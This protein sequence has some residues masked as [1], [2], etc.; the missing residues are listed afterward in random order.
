M[1]VFIQQKIFN[2]DIL[3]SVLIHPW[4]YVV[5]HNHHFFERIRYPDKRSDFLLSFSGVC[6]R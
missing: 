6:N 1:Y 5:P 3:N 2:T 4:L